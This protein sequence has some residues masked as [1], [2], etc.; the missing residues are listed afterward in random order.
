MSTERV[1][2]GNTV[3]SLYR[4]TLDKDLPQ[5]LRARLKTL[6][7]DLDAPLQAAYAHDVWVRCLDEVGRTL[8]PDLS[9]EAAR[10]KL[11]RRMIEGYA[12]TVMG[13]AVLNVENACATSSSAVRSCPTCAGE[14]I[15]GSAR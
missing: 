6:G 8:H 11:A 3:D 15:P 9:L 7:L 4:R 10:R 13:A 2:F 1:I 14:S 12:Q 5:E